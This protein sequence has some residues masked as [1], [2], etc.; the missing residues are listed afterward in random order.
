MVR[1]A[2]RSEID[3]EQATWSTPAA[4]MKA[5]RDHATPLS[6]QAL[7]ALRELQRMSRTGVTCSPASAQRTRLS[8]RTP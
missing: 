3:F 4:K 8:A 1:K 7:E 6:R 2:E 5:T